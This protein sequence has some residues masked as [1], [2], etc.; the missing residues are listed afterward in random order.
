GLRAAA[1][2]S[3]AEVA[4]DPD[5]VAQGFIQ[6]RERDGVRWPL[7]GSPVNLSATPPVIGGPIGPLDE[8]R[9]HALLIAKSRG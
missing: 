2:R 3:V 7:I 1:V 9:E 6:W 8:A 5:T 4:D